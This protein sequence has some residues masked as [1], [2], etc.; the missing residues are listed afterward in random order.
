MIQSADERNMARIATGEGPLAMSDSLHQWVPESETADLVRQDGPFL[1]GVD[2]L[3]TVWVL[4]PV[5][6]F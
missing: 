1:A 4:P 6:T 5:A 2:A 3:I